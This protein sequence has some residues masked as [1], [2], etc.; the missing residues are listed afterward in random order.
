[1]SSAPHE[2]LTQL[3]EGLVSSGASPSSRASPRTR[4]GTSGLTPLGPA[5]YPVGLIAATALAASNRRIPGPMYGIDP[6]GRA[7]MPG[8]ASS[9]ERRARA[10]LRSPD[11]LASSRR[12]SW[13]CCP[14]LIPT[15]LR[16]G[17]TFPPPTHART[18]SC[19]RAVI[20]PGVRFFWGPRRFWDPRPQVDDGNA[21]IA[22]MPQRRGIRCPDRS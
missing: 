11:A 19:P 17:R 6:L 1:L 13:P 5:L 3:R 14:T 20:G 16:R 10:G 4:L 18:H 21:G 7:G 9:R 15:R 8:A 12:S 2:A 22:R